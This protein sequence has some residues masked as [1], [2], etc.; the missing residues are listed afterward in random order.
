MRKSP[1]TYRMALIMSIAISL[2]SN[3]LSFIMFFYGRDAIE[4]WE[5]TRAEVRINP[6]LIN[7]TCNFLLA[8]ALYML[9][10]KLMKL[11]MSQNLKMSLIII[12]TIICTIV[13]SYI[14]STL[15]MNFAEY[16]YNN[17][18]RK[19]RNPERFIR[20]G[21]FRDTTIA[22]I[23][24]CSAQVIYLSYKQQQTRLEN[25]KLLAENLRTRYQSLKN[26]IN[27]HFLFNSL[28]TLNS[29]IK[30]NP[31][32]AQEYIEQLSN[33]FRYTLQNRE[34]IALEEE[35]KFTRSYC[36]LMQIRYGNNLRISY[37]IDERY[38][39]YAVIPLSL[40][41]LVENAIKHNVVSNRYPLTISI[42]T[43]EDDTISVIN[44]LQ[45]KKDKESGEGI[46][47]NNLAE[48]Y[49]MMWKREISIRQTDEIFEVK[50]P[51]KKEA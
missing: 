1:L 40:Q 29:L 43:N 38:N 20:G 12:L 23:V 27:P 24:M 41:T 35:L 42:A 46:G 31:E 16:I 25:E 19:F 36:Q 30:L 34:T 37:D 45:P 48:R 22:V 5:R 9:N 28:N 18:V 6:A 17:S 39:N 32:G 51:F 21:L 33:V 7:I 13:I 44:P 8:F 47:L 15:H 26:Q 2:L 11:N 49:R 3:L 10:F 4:P 50:I 14:I